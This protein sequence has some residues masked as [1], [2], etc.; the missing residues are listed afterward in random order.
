MSRCKN[1]TVDCMPKY[2][3]VYNRIPSYTLIAYRCI[4]SYTCAY[5]RIPSY[6]IVYICKYSYINIFT[7][8]HIF[9]FEYKHMWIYECTPHRWKMT[10]TPLQ[11]KMTPPVENESHPSSGN[12]SV[13]PT[14][15]IMYGDSSLPPQWKLIVAQLRSETENTN[16]SS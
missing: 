4:P 13:D 15:E 8:K 10:V 7:Y 5:H 6:T 16:G 9:I 2:T 3:Q 1:T 11:W 12:N 14:E